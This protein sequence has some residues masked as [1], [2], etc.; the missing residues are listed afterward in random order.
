MVHQN[1]HRRCIIPIYLQLHEDQFLLSDMYTKHFY[2][3]IEISRKLSKQKQYNL[4][5]LLNGQLIA[6]FTPSL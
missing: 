2:R 5:D 3:I 4:N 6:S 1:R